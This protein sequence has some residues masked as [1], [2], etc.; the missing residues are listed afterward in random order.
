ML[1]ENIPANIRE[2]DDSITKEILECAHKGT[3]NHNCTK[4]FRIIPDELSFY[5]KMGIPLPTLCSSCR[6]L[7][8]LK[9]RLGMELY[10]RE[11]MCNGA[12]DMTGQYRNGVSHAHGDGKC[13]ETF[14]TGYAPNGETIVYCEHC[15]QSETA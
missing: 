15:Y 6:T 11:C 1:S 5:R 14:K 7:E 3:C 2:T 10:D 13:P 12:K 9:L 4:A 8:R